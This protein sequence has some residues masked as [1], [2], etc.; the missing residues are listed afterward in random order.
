MYARSRS[1][2]NVTIGRDWDGIGE[3]ALGLGDGALER[4][5][6]GERRPDAMEVAM[7]GDKRRKSRAEVSRASHRRRRPP[8]ARGACQTARCGS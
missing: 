7:A 8:Q 6:G 5:V 3:A 4:G 2:S 1:T